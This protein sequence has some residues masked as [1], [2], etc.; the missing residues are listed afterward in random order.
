MEVV[1]RLAVIRGK[2]EIGFA[3]FF[4]AFEM[5]IEGGLGVV[6]AM[7]VGAAVEFILFGCRGGGGIVH[8]FAAPSARVTTRTQSSGVIRPRFKEE[9]P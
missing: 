1:P 7:A 4:G 5:V 2:L 9:E 6:W 8:D 3:G